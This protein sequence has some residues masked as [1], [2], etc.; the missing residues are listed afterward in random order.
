MA[1]Q[2]QLEN[3]PDDAPD[4]PKTRRT[5]KSGR[6]NPMLAVAAAFAANVV[7]FIGK[8][9]VAILSRSTSIMSEAIHSLVD[10]LDQALLFFGDK[11]SKRRADSLH[12]FGYGREKYFYAMIVGTLL[13]TVGGVYAIYHGVYTLVGGHY[14][15]TGLS[16]WVQIGLLVFAF[17]MEGS[18]LLAGLK[19]AKQQRAQVAPDDHSRFI[20]G[21]LK[22]VHRTKS[23]EL[24]ICLLEDSAALAGLVLAFLGVGLAHIFHQPIFDVAGGIAVGVL[25]TFTGL[26]IL[27]ETKSLLL[28]ES[29]DAA[30]IARI[31]HTIKSVDGVDK[32]ME[33]KAI[34]I[35]PEEILIL[36][37]VDL[38]ARADPEDTINAAEKAVRRIDHQTRFYI[39]VEVDDAPKKLSP[40]KT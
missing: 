31:A 34:N 30:L 19:I 1:Q 10:T 11:R 17:V 4:K 6:A 33:L 37:K 29:S 18:S 23:A 22:F 39:Y 28:G 15:E 13:F 12:P 27:S 21:L 5:K 38:F 25:L 24:I 9:V 7:I 32:L 26:L 36:A 20:V 16:I 14:G 40:A 2:N 35:A 3:S 8:A